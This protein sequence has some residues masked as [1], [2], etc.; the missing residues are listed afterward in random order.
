VPE[1]TKPKLVIGSVTKRTEIL[2]DVWRAAE[3]QGT[4]IKS[5]RAKLPDEIFYWGFCFLNRAFR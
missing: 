3:V 1:D 4:G 5:L 2:Q